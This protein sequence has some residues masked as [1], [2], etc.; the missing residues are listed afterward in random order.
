MKTV[1]QIQKVDV[2]K[3]AFNDGKDICYFLVKVE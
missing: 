3:K 1:T 2:H